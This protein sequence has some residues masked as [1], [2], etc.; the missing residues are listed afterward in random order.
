MSRLVNSEP[1]LTPNQIACGQNLK[2]IAQALEL[3]RTKNSDQY[4]SIEDGLSA[5]SPDYLDALPLCAD[6]PDSY[7]ILYGE[8][9]DNFENQEDYYLI[10]CTNHPREWSVNHTQQGL[11][12]YDLQRG[13]IETVR[14]LEKLPQRR[15]KVKSTP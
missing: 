3:Y 5:L 7:H 6:G 11:P 8:W 10:W 12:R 15:T 13:L 14:D 2:S 9:A 4:P 1:S